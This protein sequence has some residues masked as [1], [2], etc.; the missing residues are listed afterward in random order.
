[1]NTHMIQPKLTELLEEKG[2]TLYRLA[3]ETDLAYSTLHKFSNG[4]TES[5]DFRVLDLICETLDC[6]PGDVL[7]RVP[8]GSKGTRLQPE[9]ATKKRGSAK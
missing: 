2:V 6:Q 3:K 5:I 1:M 7:V 9:R 4:R 8:N